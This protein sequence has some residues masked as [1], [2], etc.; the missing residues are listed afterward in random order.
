[1]A[2][3]FRGISVQQGGEAVLELIGVRLYR[4]VPNILMEQEAQSTARTTRS[5][6][7]KSCSK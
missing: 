1:M 6:V 3:I 2:H 4:Q 5:L 7:S